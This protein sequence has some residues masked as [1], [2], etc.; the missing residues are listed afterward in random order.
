MSTAITYLNPARHRLNLTVKAKVVVKRIL[1]SDKRASAVE[2]ES[3]GETF[4]VEGDEIVLS[5]GATA[6]P[7]LLM[8]SGVG[9]ADHLSSLGIPIVHDLP[10][11]GQNFRDHPGVFIGLNIKEEYRVDP[12]SPNPRIVL[13]YTAQGSPTR[14][15]MQIVPARMAGPYNV[16]DLQIGEVRIVCRLYLAKSAGQVRLTSTD[17]HVQPYLDFKFLEDPW[18]RERFREGV[19]IIMRLLK[20]DAIKDMIKEIVTPTEQDMTSDETLDSWLMRHVV[21]GAHFT[22][23]CKMGPSSDPMAV[24]DQYGRVRGVEGL[25]VSDASIIPEVPRANTNCS[26][27]MVAERVAEWIKEGRS[28]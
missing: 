8:L 22:G 3:D 5:A 18:D 12:D 27:I 21:G 9:A 16:D 17:P 4:T 15:D 20:Q 23:T 25:R 26:T 1:F 7:K 6:S 13:R 24:V 10:G 28:N 19:R 2:V 11:V 14:G